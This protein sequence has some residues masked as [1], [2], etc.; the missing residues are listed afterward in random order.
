[1]WWLNT[2]ILIT[3]LEIYKRLI[4]ILKNDKG[5]FKTIINGY[6]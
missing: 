1:M 5:K 4:I 3:K 2:N 6:W